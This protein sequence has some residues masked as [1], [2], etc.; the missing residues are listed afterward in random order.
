MESNAMLS[1]C[2]VADCGGSVGGSGFGELLTLLL[3][4]DHDIVPGACPETAFNEQV[5]HIDQ[6]AQRNA[7]RLAGGV[8]ELPSTMPAQMTESSIHAGITVTMPA[9]ISM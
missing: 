4:D 7:W 6:P 2:G 9:A 8:R 3:L 1:W 5:M